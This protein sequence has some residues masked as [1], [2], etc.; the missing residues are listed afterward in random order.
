MFACFW[1]KEVWS[2]IKK[3][4]F[5]SGG[6]FV[7]DFVVCWLKAEGGGGLGLEVGLMERGIWTIVDFLIGG[8]CLVYLV[9]DE[10]C[11]FVYFGDGEKLCE[12]HVS[13][14]IFY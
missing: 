2:L 8:L 6:L 9:G 14:G 12:V 7:F 5:G 3:V 1:G 13:V 4:N 10:F 11:I